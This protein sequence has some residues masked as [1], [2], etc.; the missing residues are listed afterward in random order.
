[1]GYD[2][3]LHIGDRVN[4]LYDGDSYNSKIVRFVKK[5]KGVENI[6]ILLPTKNN[7]SMKTD[8]D[9]KKYEVLF[10]TKGDKNGSYSYCRR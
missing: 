8:D 6:V 4:I 10:Y 7:L 5:I 9:K 3:Y 2:K 1:M